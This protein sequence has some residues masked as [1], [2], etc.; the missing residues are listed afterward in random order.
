MTVT[1]IT[2]AIIIAAP[3]IHPSSHPW[4]ITPIIIDT[5]AAAHNILS[6]LS[7]RVSKISYKIVFGGSIY[8]W[9]VPNLNK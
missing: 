6:N 3:S 4:V 2:T 9:F 5:A 8:G 7:S 1:I